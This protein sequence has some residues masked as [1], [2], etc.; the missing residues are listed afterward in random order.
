M[1]QQHHP[2]RGRQPKVIATVVLAGC[3]FYIASSIIEPLTNRS[4][5]YEHFVPQNR[6]LLAV[7]DGESGSIDKP[8]SMRSGP[9]GITIRRRSEEDAIAVRGR[10]RAAARKRADKIAETED[11]RL[12]PEVFQSI[13]ETA[14][15]LV[16]PP[17]R[18]HDV[19]LFD[20]DSA[21]LAV[22][23]F[24]YQIL[25]FVYDSATDD[26][27][28]LHNLP[29]CDFGCQRAYIIAPVLAAA[30]RMNYP[31]R[32]RGKDSGDLV[33]LLST[34]DMPRIRRPCL[35]EE[36][37]YCKSD[38]WAPILQ[39][40]SILADP[41]Y[42]PSVIAMPPSPRPHI[43]CFREFQMTG[44]VCKD[45]QPRTFDV[46]DNN[47][48]LSVENPEEN[49]KMGKHFQHGLVFGQEMDLLNPPD[50]YWDNL[51][52]QII[53]RGTDFLFL[54]TLYP[55]MRSPTY[56]EDISPKQHTFGDDPVRGAIKTLWEKGDDILTP[57][58]KGVLL[59]SQAELEAR[60]IQE[61][62]AAG[63]ALPWVNIKFASCNVNGEKVPAA[64]NED[65]QVLQNEFGIAAIGE[66]MSMTEQARYKYHIDIG[67]GGGTTWTG[68]LEK[69]AMPGVLF[70]HVTPTKDWF[71]DH[72]QPWVHYIP[73]RSDLSDLRSKYEWAES[74]PK[75]AQRISENGTEFA[76]YFGSQEGFSNLYQE[77]IVAPLGKIIASYKVPRRKH[78]TKR[79]LD[80]LKDSE[81]KGVKDGFGIVAR[82]G[83]WPAENTECRWT[84]K[85]KKDGMT[86]I[87]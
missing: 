36:N 59:T 70:H 40:G 18:D 23:A 48:A 46:D 83:G 52:P 74:N 72:I 43:P 86:A 84:M 31:S 82:C 19:P 26:F 81:Y 16:I 64:Q 10:A 1:E 33:F 29:T 41:K 38:Q 77:H 12:P 11:S 35:F 75:E 79:V 73:V 69:L 32:F 7:D 71:H 28:V 53:W 85:N 5:D 76:R 27:V 47:R 21:L 13:T 62:E 22:R 63:Q 9:G 66:P 8:K 57:R 3:L 80:I 37:K 49:L 54:H 17:E 15:Q 39:F 68:T 55:D 51:T 61:S 45:L 50:S 78:G 60:E 14:Q 42:M 30:L 24:H 4:I 6:F 58:W 34:G 56:A 44:Q 25:F 87:E 65:F 2:R 20:I 67:G